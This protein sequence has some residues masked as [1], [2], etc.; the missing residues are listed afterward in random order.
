M[1]RRTRIAMSSEETGEASDVVSSPSDIFRKFYSSDAGVVSCG[2]A[3]TPEPKSILKVKK[4]TTPIVSF[5][6]SD[7]EEAPRPAVR[8]QVVVEDAPDAVGLEVLERT[9]SAP[10]QQATDVQQVN[11]HRP[12]SRFKASRMNRK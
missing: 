7:S 1:G 4:S 9:P 10:A 5:P 6:D 11:T 3:A 2:T 8:R 12:V